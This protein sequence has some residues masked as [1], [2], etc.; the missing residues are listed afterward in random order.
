MAGRMWITIRRA[1]PW[2]KPIPHPL[3]VKDSPYAH[4]VPYPATIREPVNVGIDPETGTPLAIPLWDKKG[5][6]VVLIAG[7]KDA[8]KTVLL[9]NLRAG[10]TACPDAIMLQVNLAKA[11]QEEHWSPLAEVTAALAD[12]KAR[13][14]L[15][16][17]RD[18]VRARTRSGR[19]TPVHQ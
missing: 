8:G 16:F 15:L 2:A 19:K 10:I 6:K 13:R 5:A 3:T 18:A 11:L 9:N 17:T 7:K 12:G 4:L 14:T 1:D